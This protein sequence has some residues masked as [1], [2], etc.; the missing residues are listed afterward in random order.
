MSLEIFLLGQFKLI[1]NNNPFEL[2]SRPAQSLLAYLVLNPG[3]SLRRE[4]LA[5][6]IW[7]ES[8][9]R[10]ARSYLR[11]AL[12]RL[13][14]SFEQ[15]SLQWED[16]LQI[17]EIS[18]SFKV[19][20]DYWLDV[21]QLRK[22][23]ADQSLEQSIADLRLYR[24]ELLPGFYEEWIGL[25]RDRIQATY[26]QKIDNLLDG[27]IDTNRWQDVLEWGEQWIRYGFSPE[28][29]YRALMRAYAALRNPSMVISTY[30]RC[31]EA[32][33]R[34]LSITPSP[35]TVQL[36]DHIRQ[37]NLNKLSSSAAVV[38]AMREPPAFFSDKSQT[39]WMEKPLVVAREREL[40]Q[41]DGYLNQAS[42][43]QGKVVFIT[44]EAG[45]G[46]TTLINE[47]IR[48]AQT[49]S[50]D[51]IV[52]NG[53]CNANTG[54][55]D[56]YLPFRE[57]LGLLTGDVEARWLAGAISQK[58]A[59]FL[60]NLIPFTTQALLDAGPDLMD[61]LISGAALLERAKA[62]E[63]CQVEWLTRLERIIIQ[64]DT[65]Q[66]ARNPHQSDLFIQ[67]SKVLHILSH[68]G[69]VIL[70]VDDLQWADLGSISLL[71]HLG[72]N[73]AGSRI[74]I[75][76]AYRPEEIALGRA[77]ERHP[78]ESVIN[79]LQR[80]YGEIEV[81]T[82]WDESRTFI[83]ALLDSE[84][85][86]LGDNF[87]EKLSQLTH[88][89][90]LFTIELLRG[91]QERGDLI[92]DERGQWIEAVTLDWERLPARTEAV[93]A[94]RIGRLNPQLKSILQVASVE[95]EVFTAEVV[96]RVLGIS[97]HNILSLL[98]GEL[99]RR[100]RLIQA[101]SIVR[102]NEQRLS[103]YR[104]RHNLIQKYLYSGLDEV[105]RVCLH[106]QVGVAL[107]EFYK[108]EEDSVIDLDIVVLLARHFQEAGIKLKALNY[109][110]RA[111]RR[112]LL[113]SGYQEA[114]NHLI[115]GLGLIETITDPTERAERELAFQLMIGLAYQGSQGG[116]WSELRRAYTRASELCRQIGN[117]NQ[118]C[119]VL[120]EM[121]VFY[122]VHA[123]HKK[124]RDL[125][126]D[127][128]NLAQDSD[129]PL[130]IMFGHWY[131]GFCLFCLGEYSSA[132]DHLKK[133]T[134][135]YN[136][137]QH[138]QKLIAL[139]G[140]DAGLSAMA[141]EA[142]CLWCLGYPESAFKRGQEALTLAQEFG[143]PF[144]MADV[145]CYAGCLLGLMRQDIETLYDN[146]QALVELS[147]EIGLGWWQ[148]GGCFLGSAL[149]MKGKLQDGISLMQDGIQYSKSMEILPLLSVNLSSLA[150][151]QMG[152]GNIED[153]MKILNE[154]FDFIENTDQRQ[155]EVELYCLKGKILS[156]QGDQVAAKENFSTAVMIANHRGAKSWELRATLDLC[157]LLNDQG[158][159][160]EA[161][162]ILSG[163]YNWFSEGFDTPDLISAKALLE[164]LALPA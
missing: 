111:A 55:G 81:N 61:T 65:G 69:L 105:E 39:H 51:L 162:S 53:N 22:P 132:L 143:H 90:P 74:L 70:V 93:I 50:D 141:Y 161:L 95:G 2:P 43:G 122:Y 106:E 104:F 21:D 35:E 108:K 25:E 44:G 130:L 119:Q 11:Q 68:R 78:L 5:S 156:L 23:V 115:E 137:Y 117:I 107:E 124:A 32:L 150:E 142:C 98:S 131:L 26:N 154:A 153:G 33:D 144:T 59:Q 157:R 13:R 4:M 73:L 113:L 9:E 87:R 27:L 148:S 36:Y 63:I 80:L 158:N 140:K 100:H 41:L 116:Q 114:I 64:K 99:D 118:L 145:H 19:Q 20:S 62:Y 126:F 3:A 85:N 60:W 89:Q 24:G 54:L 71:F 37:A 40:R 57:I 92:H 151:A 121:A 29:A 10:N 58:Y 31:V 18:I 123:E 72:R 48:C 101:Q 136:P 46:K 97:E 103:H 94:E 16:Y 12:W 28:P 163:I 133:V 6:L 84:P 96:A 8:S 88:G 147:N 160:S 125:A 15:V 75:I 14:K 109:L 149:A 76:C 38:K 129:D 139:R 17:G 34:D 164:E 56:P 91:M 77:G 152:L 66:W 45:S 112:A 146:A 42:S 110:Y 1:A 120:G 127:A 30:Q 52:A 155:W 159:K 138:H 47:F 49:A 7:P 135:F 86:Q 83:K 79:E 82:D 134:S 102:R 128:L 67:Y